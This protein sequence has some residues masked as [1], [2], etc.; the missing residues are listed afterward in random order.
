VLGTGVCG[1][2]TTFSTFAYETVRL[3]E[4]GEAR[5][6]R[7]NLAASLLLPAMAAA[8]GLAIAAL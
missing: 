5:A 4:E 6:A 1:A 8:L 3:A 2:Y 7:F